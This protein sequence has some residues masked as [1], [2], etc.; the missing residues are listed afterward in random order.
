MSFLSKNDAKSI[1]KLIRKYPEF[2]PLYHDIAEFR[3]D[4]KELM[5]MFSEALY[6]LDRNTERLMVDELQ[7]ERDEAVA[8]L[9]AANSA[10][11]D[12]D[13]ELADKNAEINAANA[14]I[15]ELEKQLA[16]KESG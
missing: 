9:D 16:D 4:P 2:I 15:A 14:R 12:K 3:R 10:L 8:R 5:H 7:E 6:I 13:A 1:L 11:A